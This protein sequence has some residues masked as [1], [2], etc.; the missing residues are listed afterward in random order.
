MLVPWILLQILKVIRSKR[1]QITKWKKTGDLP[2]GK[3]ERKKKCN[4]QGTNKASR[5]ILKLKGP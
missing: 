1:N 3:I 2:K 5:G 4:S